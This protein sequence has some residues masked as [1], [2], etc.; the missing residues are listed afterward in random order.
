MYFVSKSD[1]LDMFQATVPH[2]RKMKWSFFLNNYNVETGHTVIP[3]KKYAKLHEIPV[4]DL[5]DL[6][7]HIQTREEYLGRF[8]DISLKPLLPLTITDPPMPL[9][10]INNNSEV[11]YKNIV[12]NMYYRDILE[13]TTSGIDNVKSFLMVLDDL[14]NHRIIDY[15]ILT[16]SARFYT[17]NGRIG[18]V[19]SSFYFRASI[20][21]PYVIYSLNERLLKGTRIFTPTL[22]WSSYCYGFMECPGVTEYVGNDVI[23]NVCK[24][25][26]K[27]AQTFYPDKTCAIW[28]EPS[29]DLLT[30]P[31]FMREYKS[32]FDVVFFSPPYYRLEMYPGKKQ[33]TVRYKTYQEWLQGYWEKTIQLCWHVLQ[34]GGR[35]CYI[36]SNYQEAE[37]PQLTLV[38]DMIQ[39][40]KN[41]G[42]TKRG[43]IRPMWNKTVAVNIDPGDNHE[44]I[45]LFIKSTK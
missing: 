45:C 14:Y 4:A 32:H 15:K 9:S 34:P 5:R 36:V 7:D 19:F 24:K 10:N 18:S 38:R 29:E 37:N 28:C 17:K 35:L 25:T 11:K 39:V 20:L 26:T 44:N 16:P 41:C 21:N 8:Y 31:E 22:G 43:V 42:F 6:F 3:L 1:F 30:N 2:N 33:S 40:T 27:F 13:R 12:R 23:P